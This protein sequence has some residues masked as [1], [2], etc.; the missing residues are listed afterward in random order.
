MMLGRALRLVPIGLLAIC[1]PEACSAAP[2]SPEISRGIES[3]WPRAGVLATPQDCVRLA[4]LRDAAVVAVP[5]AVVDDKTLIAY[6]GANRSSVDLLLRIG[7]LDCWLGDRGRAN[8]GYCRLHYEHA[9]ADGAAG[10]RVKRCVNGVRSR[11]G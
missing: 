6:I 5:T 10:G 3:Q 2:A 9:R 8:G 7:L 4:G 11:A 1:M